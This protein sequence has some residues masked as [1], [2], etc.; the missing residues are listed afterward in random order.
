VG[1][2]GLVGG[3]VGGFVC[4]TYGFGGMTVVVG[5]SVGAIVGG[6]VIGG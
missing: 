3:C 1:R 6:T 2:V 4:G 5:A